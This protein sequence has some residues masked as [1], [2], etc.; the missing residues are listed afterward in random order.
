MKEKEDKKK[1]LKKIE[2]EEYI[3]LKKLSKPELLDKAISMSLDVYKGQ[4]IKRYNKPDI[5]KCILENKKN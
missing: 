4:S 5:I 3:E 2:D 1:E